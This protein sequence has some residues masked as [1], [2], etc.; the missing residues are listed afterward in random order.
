MSKFKTPEGTGFFLG[1]EEYSDKEM[2]PP[3][4]DQQALQEPPPASINRPSTS[5]Q[6][7]REAN[8]RRWDKGAP[9]D[10]D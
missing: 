2:L 4:P 8:R 10:L 5:R 1:F 6:Q 3:K 7:Q 9:I